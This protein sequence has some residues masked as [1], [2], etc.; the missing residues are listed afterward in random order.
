MATA[1]VADQL[2]GSIAGVLLRNINTHTHTHTHT[3]T[4]RNTDKY[5]HRHSHRHTRLSAHTQTHTPQTDTDTHQLQRLG[6]WHRPPQKNRQHR[7]HTRPPA[8]GGHNCL[9]KPAKPGQK[10]GLFGHLPL[11]FSSRTWPRQ[12][13]SRLRH[14]HAGCRL[15]QKA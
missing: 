8:G 3:N 13:G 1:K 5:P 7:R 15:D 11:P 4:Y 12:T 6:R 14:L 2:Q 9:L 10:G